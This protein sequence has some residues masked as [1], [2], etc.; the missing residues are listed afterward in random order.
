MAPSFHIPMASREWMAEGRD[1]HQPRG[2]RS[3]ISLLSTSHHV[4]IISSTDT[5]LPAPLSRLGCQAGLPDWCCAA[6]A[7]CMHTAA[8][9]RA[10]PS[11]T[12]SLMCATCTQS[13]TCAICTTEQSGNLQPLASIQLYDGTSLKH[14]CQQLRRPCPERTFTGRLLRAAAVLSK[15]PL[16]QGHSPAAPAYGC[17]CCD[18]ICSLASRAAARE[19]G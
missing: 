12:Q 3:K 5:S 9:W 6:P 1:D 19:C 18:W 10:Q 4:D 7:C 13:L 17:L 11:Q 8:T 14:P 15:P 2:S 16:H